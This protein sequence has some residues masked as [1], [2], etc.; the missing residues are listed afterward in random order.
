MEK[1]TKPAKSGAVRHKSTAVQAPAHPAKPPFPIVGIGASAGGLEALEQFFRQVPE[2]SGMAFVVIQHLDPTHKGIMPE[3]LQRSTGMEIFQVRDRMRV[4]P[5]CVYV[6]PP[7]RDMSILHGVLHLF[8]PTAAR[9]LRLPIDFFLRS[10]ADDQ[11]ERS[12]GVILSGM[13]SD[14]TEGLRAI[15]GHGGLVR[16]AGAGLGQIR[17][18]AAQRH[19]CRTRRP[20][21]PG[22]GTARQNPRLS[23]PCADS[24]QARDRARGAGEERPGEGR[25]P[26]PQQD[27]PGL[28]ALQEEHSV[29]PYRAAHG[30]PSDRPH[31]QL[32]PLPAEQSPG[33]GNPFQGT[34]DRRDQFFPR[35]PGMG[36]AGRRGAA[37]A[38]AGQ[39]GGRRHPRLVGGLF[40][41]GGGLFPGDALQGDPGAAETGAKLHPADFRHRPGRGRHRSGPPG[42]LPGQHRRRSHGRAPEPVFRPGIE[43]ATGSARRFGKWS[44]SPSRT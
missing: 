44:P 32:C 5:N 33:S 2:K 40:D 36:A 6:I 7:N 28:L 18:H 22:R 1:P 23:A 31:R 29:P 35:P 16:S 12:I 42:S 39:A 27:R 43:R 41:G 13:G 19:R 30:H 37:G 20:G 15:K 11:Q 10:L 21:G 3:L 24:Q 14:G 8:E 4:K 25:H 9:G 26:A 17:Q 34:A 38:A